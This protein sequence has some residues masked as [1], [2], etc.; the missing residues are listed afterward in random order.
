M[1]EELKRQ[2]KAY[3]DKIEKIPE[4]KQKLETE[5]VQRHAG[6][7]PDDVQE[8]VKGIVESHFIVDLLE[9]WLDILTNYLNHIRDE[10]MVGVKRWKA[11][12]AV[13]TSFEKVEQNYAAENFN[14]PDTNFGWLGEADSTATVV[15]G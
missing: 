10:T 11:V 1:F 2:F 15:S 3:L 5:V 13:K 6:A 9:P 8:I 14:W 12:E 4:L 7:T